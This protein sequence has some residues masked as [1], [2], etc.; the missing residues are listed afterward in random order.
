MRSGYNSIFSRQ[1]SREHSIGPQSNIRIDPKGALQGDDKSDSSQEKSP[2]KPGKQRT[3]SIFKH[4]KNKNLLENVEGQNTSTFAPY[5]RGITAQDN[6]VNIPEENSV[7]HEKSVLPLMHPIISSTT[8]TPSMFPM[9]KPNQAAGSARNNLKEMMRLRNQTE[10]PRTGSAKPNF[11][12]DEDENSD[13]F[14]THSKPVKRSEARKP[15]TNI[16]TKPKGDEYKIK[17]GDLNV[18]IGSGSYATVEKW[19]K[20]ESGEHYV[21]KLMT[22]SHVTARITTSYSGINK[23]EVREIAKQLCD[24]EIEVSN[25]LGCHPNISTIEDC[26]IDKAGEEYRFFSKFADNGTLFS[27][28]HIEFLKIKAEEKSSEISIDTIKTLF[29]EIVEGVK[30]SKQRMT[31]VHSKGIVHR[32]IKF[33]NILIFEDGTAKLTDFSVSL[34]VN[35]CD[36]CL[37]KLGTT[38]IC[39]SPEL[40][41]NPNYLGYSHDIWSLGVVLWQMIFKKT[42]FNVDDG[43]AIFKEAVLS[44]T[45]VFPEGCQDQHLMTLLS[46]MLRQDPSQRW[47]IEQVAKSSWLV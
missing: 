27:D 45:P 7:D 43:E 11:D 18:K 9:A 34:C 12:E 46:E 33:E 38:K 10:Y 2:I 14:V 17:Y 23:K 21:M 13:I 1:S 36:S 37:L 41:L 22:I 28:R 35:K 47:D 29:K 42:P 26:Y 8:H 39:Q 40:L 6:H 44:F 20:R 31:L 30:H 3:G 32:D 15:G 4:M 24:N 5:N 16:Q 25:A 19:R